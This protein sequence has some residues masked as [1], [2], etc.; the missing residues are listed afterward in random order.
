M[1]RLLLEGF[2]SALLPCS[3][4]LAVPALAVALASRTE[5]TSGLIGFATSLVGFSWLR[6]SDRSETLSAM[7][8]A[9]LLAAGAVILVMPVIRRL[10]VVSAL[11]G[12]LVGIAAAELWEPCV[13]AAFGG[14][15]DD[16]PSSGGGGMALFAIY[17]VGVMAPMIAIGVGLHLLPDVITL[18]LRPVMLVVGVATLAVLSF[19]VA[20]GQQDQIL[21]RLTQLS[22]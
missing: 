8:I 17:L 6:F 16:L 10:D 22:T 2:S 5:S 4:T 20:I 1:I 18:P 14:L 15:L 21:G 12:L 19:T 13:G 3:L 7:T 11:G 9:G